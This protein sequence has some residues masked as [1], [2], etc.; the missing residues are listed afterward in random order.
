[1]LLGNADDIVQHLCEELGWDL[2]ELPL[3][4]QLDAPRPNLR[5]RSSDAFVREPRRVGNR[6]VPSMFAFCL[7]K[8]TLIVGTASHV[9][10]FEGAEGGK[11]VDDIE[12]K[13]LGLVADDDGE[14]SAEEDEDE[15]EQD[16]QAQEVVPQVKRPRTA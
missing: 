2:P 11:W 14:T 10:L 7:W 4:R 1:M 3:A 13:S 16:A 15:D 8:E 6:W 12:K 5:K 9:W